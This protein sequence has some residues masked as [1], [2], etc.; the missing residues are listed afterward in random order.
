M[1][2]RK[3]ARGQAAS[4]PT[5]EAR[6][7]NSMDLD[8]PVA[9]EVG[10]MPSAKRDGPE[11]NDMWTDDQIASLF[12]AVIRWKPAGMHK[13]F[14]MIAISEHLRNHGFDPDIYQHTRIPNIWDKLRTYY[15]L[16]AI[17]ER[18]YFEDDELDEKY[19]DFSLPRSKFLDSMMRRA[20]ADFSEAPTSPAEL[21]IS[22]EPSQARKRKRSG[23][24]SKARDTDAYDTEDGDDVPLPASRPTRGL[25][26]S[27]GRTRAAYQ[28]TKAEKNDRSEKNDKAETTEEEDVEEDEE[29]EEEEEDD[30]EEEQE[31]ES[32]SDEEDEESPEEE[33][34]TPA[35]RSTRAAARKSAAPKPTARRTRSRR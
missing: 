17:D 2:P 8:T 33:G 21:D 3:R 13:H 34:G 23:T 22:P 5:T 10:A 32:G 25:R 30:E 4:T 20:V 27:R 19:V 15:D 18:E 35:S 7:K 28:Q 14:R 31:G 24:A 12:K 9:S 29:E 11:Y 16:D 6:D 26:R 1:P